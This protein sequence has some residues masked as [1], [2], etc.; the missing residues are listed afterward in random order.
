MQKGGNNTFDIRDANGKDNGGTD[1]SDGNRLLI[2]EAA[3][4]KWEGYHG[5]NLFQVKIADIPNANVDPAAAWYDIFWIR[6]F[7]SKED[8]VKFAEDEIK[9]N[10]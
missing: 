10:K 3:V 1:L 9:N 7:K 6:S 5:F 8:A 2:W 4:G